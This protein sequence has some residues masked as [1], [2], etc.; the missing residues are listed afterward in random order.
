MYSCKLKLLLGCS[1]LWVLTVMPASAQSEA[2]PLLRLGDAYAE[3]GLTNQAITE[4]WRALYEAPAGDHTFYA[5]YQLGMAYAITGEPS[6]SAAAFQRAIRQAPDPT[7]QG[8]VRIRLATEQLRAGQF[9]HAKLELLQSIMT[10]TSELQKTQ[11]H[12]LLGLAFAF[13]ENWSETREAFQHAAAL[14]PENSSFIGQMDSLMAALD[15]L[16]FGKKGKSPKTAKWASTFLPGAGQMY[17]GKLWNG[18]NAMAINGATTYLVVS[19]FQRGSIRDA[20]LLLTGIWW[21]YY[22]GN[23]LHA[24]EDT[25]RVNDQHRAALVDT[26]FR[27]LVEATGHLPDDP[28]IRLD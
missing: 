21:R 13:Q 11:A 9:E 7:T 25:E 16:E 24:A 28:Q 26:L 20:V 12:L 18:V 14:Q 15:A 23:R 8:V 2:V 3:A 5:Y 1:L 27:H 17:A 22:Q 19:A 6:K 4:Y 10:G